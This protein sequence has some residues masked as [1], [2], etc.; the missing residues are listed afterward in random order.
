M[1]CQM[2]DMLSFL[3]SLRDHP[4]TSMM[5]TIALFTD[6]AEDIPFLISNQLALANNIEKYNQGSVYIPL[7]YVTIPE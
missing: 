3:S 5:A 4:L 6:M 1:A 7:K 2:A